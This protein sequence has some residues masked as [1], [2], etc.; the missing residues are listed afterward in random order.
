MKAKYLWKLHANK[1]SVS[2]KVRGYRLRLAHANLE[3][4]CF[5]EPV[6]SFAKR[7]LIAES[8]DYS[9]EMG[10]E[11]HFDAF[12]RETPRFLNIKPEEI[13]HVSAY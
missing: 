10:A 3:G 9:T 6:P 7:F 2:G 5:G 13:V 1:A 11:E 12:L 4:S 8:G